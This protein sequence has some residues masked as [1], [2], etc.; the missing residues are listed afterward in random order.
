MV[1]YVK[2]DIYQ[3]YVAASLHREHVINAGGDVDGLE[4]DI[5]TAKAPLS[6]V[7]TALPKVHFVLNFMD[8]TQ[9]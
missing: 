4:E 1:K 2:K 7:L 5:A 9:N 8:Q 3:D 6:E